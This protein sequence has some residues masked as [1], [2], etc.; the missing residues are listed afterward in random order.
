MTA[1]TYA[2]RYKRRPGSARRAAI[3]APA[4][5]RGEPPRGVSSRADTSD[6][7]NDLTEV[8]KAIIRSLKIG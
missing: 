4:V 1:V 5:M 6:V 8:E 7:A 3:E 2:H